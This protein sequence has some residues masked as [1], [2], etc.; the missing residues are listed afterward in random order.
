MKTGFTFFL[1][2]ISISLASAQ[3]I[4]TQQQ[5]SSDIKMKNYLSL[6]AKADVYEQKA[7]SELSITSFF[8]SEARKLLDSAY[9]VVK[10][11]EADKSYAQFYIMQFKL[12]YELAEKYTLKADSSLAVATKYKDTANIQ[13]KEAEAYYLKIAEDY[14][15][16]INSDSD[17]LE[18]VIYIVQIGAGKMDE[19]YFDKVSEVHVITPKDG[20]RRYFVGEFRSKETA[21]EYRNKMV[22]LGFEDAFIRTLDS[23]H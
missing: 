20:I 16:V 1:L 10:K 12:L 15:P 13:N 18:S 17:T 22:A 19:S 8:K 21:I 23:L 14:K 3:N 9:V 4:F 2:C 11:G 5:D 6:V 7:E